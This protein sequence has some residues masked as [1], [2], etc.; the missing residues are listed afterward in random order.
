MERR[1]KN[2]AGLENLVA[3]LRPQVS[4]LQAHIVNVQ[5]SYETEFASQK[6]Y[7]ARLEDE[8]KSKDEHILYLEK[9][10]QGLQ[11]GRIFRLTRSISR[12]L[13]K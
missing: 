13:R 12:F 8:V 5:T 1:D 6:S 7:I 3:T 11:S 10:L 9:L 4:E 2:I